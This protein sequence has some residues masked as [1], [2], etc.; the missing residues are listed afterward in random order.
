MDVNAA[1]LA[2][3]RD[4][5]ARQREARDAAIAAEAD[6]AAWIESQV[7]AGRMQQIGPD[8]YRVLTGWDAGEVFTVRRVGDQVEVVAQHGLD[9]STGG[10]A[11]YTRR[12]EWHNVGTVIP[13]GLTSIESVLRAARIDWRATKKRLRYTTLADDDPALSTLSAADLRVSPDDYVVI[14]EDTGARLGRVGGLYEVIQQRDMFRFLEDLTESGDVVWETAGALRGG[15]KVFVTAQIPE[16]IIVDRGGLDDEIQLYL[17][18]INSHDG[19]SG[20]EAVVTPWRIACSNTE[21]FAVRDARTR[22]KI[23][24]TPNALQRVAQARDTLGLTLKYAQQWEQE[25]TQ[26]AR[27]DILLDEVRGLIDELWPLKDDADASART[28]HHTRADHI[29]ALFEGESQRLG[30]SAY[31]AERTMTDFLDHYQPRG[32]RTMSEEVA[33]ATA[34]LEGADDERKS[35]VHRRLMRLVRA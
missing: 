2:E 17:A 11:L 14:R 9:T 21:R 24:H 29:M 3:K 1:F 31:A 26:L 33:R 5:L 10:V 6:K 30:R 28:R 13:D 23:R 18:V 25:E 15:R 34:L 20:A 35:T 4:Q 12:P 7:A 27:T 16:S 8:R 19:R 22:W 32:S